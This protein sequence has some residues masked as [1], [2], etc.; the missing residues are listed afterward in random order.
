MCAKKKKKNTRLLDTLVIEREV[1]THFAIYL[2]RFVSGKKKIEINIESVLNSTGIREQRAIHNRSRHVHT[3]SPSHIFYIEVSVPRMKQDINGLRD[4]VRSFLARFL[5]I[6]DRWR[7]LGLRFYTS[8]VLLAVKG[9]KE[10]ERKR[11]GECARRLRF[12]ELCQRK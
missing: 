4:A 7:R 1:R 2:V 9:D 6:G 5:P 10:K 3:T 8:W 12:Y 11:M